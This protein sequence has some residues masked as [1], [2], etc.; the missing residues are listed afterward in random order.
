MAPIQYF[1]AA[2]LDGYIAEVDGGID[3]LTKH[4]GSTFE[5]GA[6]PR[7]QNY[8]AGVGSMAVGADTYAI[9]AGHTEWLYGSRPTWVFTHRDLSVPEGADVRF[10]QGD[11]APHAEALREAAGDRVAWVVGGGRLASQFAEAGL[12]DE[13]LVTVVPVV[14][15]A[16]IPLFARRLPAKLALSE[17]KPYFNGMVGLHYRVSR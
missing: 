6:D 17:V 14:L 11:V 7:P 8:V 13:V 12:L 4:E 5:G 16:G 1:A 15:G 9:M 10:V 2:S 3:W